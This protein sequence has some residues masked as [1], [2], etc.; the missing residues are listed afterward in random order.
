MIFFQLLTSLVYWILRLPGLAKR[1][2]FK[3]AYNSSA[4]TIQVRVQ[5]KCAYYSSARTIQM[6]ILFKCAYNSRVRL[7]FLA[8]PVCVRPY[9]KS[10]KLPYCTVVHYF[11]ASFSVLTTLTIF[12][13]FGGAAACRRECSG[14]GGKPLYVGPYLISTRCESGISFG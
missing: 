9:P 2:L 13:Y 3:C 12:L 11:G 4:R 10:P 1:L 8:V 7:L 14:N 6:Y 5:F